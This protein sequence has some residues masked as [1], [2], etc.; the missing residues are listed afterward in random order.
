MNEERYHIIM[1]VGNKIKKLRTYKNMTQSELADGI[2]TRNMLSAIE[3]SKALPSLT[4]LRMLADKLD[5]SCDVLLSDDELAIENTVL[6]EKKLPQIKKLFLGGSYR[7]VVDLGHELEEYDNFE[8]KYILAS[9]YLNLASESFY[10]ADYDKTLDYVK[11]SD[12][13]FSSIGMKEL[14][15]QCNFLERMSKK[16]S[17]EIV[18]TVNDCVENERTFVEIIFYLHIIRLIDSGLT[19]K[20]ADVYDS[21]KFTYEPIRYHINS[22][23]AAAK[24]N[25]I[26]A[27]E[28]LDELIDKKPDL[29]LPFMKIIYNELEHY[30]TLTGDYKRAYECATEKTKLKRNGHR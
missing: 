6:P 27:K 14:S 4:V 12:R 7:E 24:F 26:H 1:D 9:S 25:I 17:Q 28:L 29:P 20:A 30:C 10:D 23:L 18:P 19:D 22:R 3:N 2:I 11:R 21:L 8:I 5:V 13:I 15:F 16:M